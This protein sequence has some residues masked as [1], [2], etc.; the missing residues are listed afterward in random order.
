[1]LAAVLMVTTASAQRGG[2]PPAPP[3]TPRAA[4]PVDLTGTWVAV[5]TED[6][7]WRMTTPKKGDYA[8]VPLNPAGRTLADQWTPAEEGSCKA[9]GAAALLRHPGRLRISWQGDATLKIE[10]DAGTQT[11]LLQFT[12]D[13]AVA[14][15]RTLQGVSRAQW[16]GVAPAWGTLKV[17]TTGLAAG[18]LRTNG[19]PYSENAVVTEYFD[20]FSDEGDEWF[21]VTTIVEDPAYLTQPFITSSNFRRE[22]DNSRWSPTTCKPS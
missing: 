17:V 6:W 11:R 9:Y 12:N 16:Q 3:R 10:T 7:H 19:V 13:A 5:I 21:A 20:R 22:P 2:G 15:A 1:M 8:S 14:G 18:W 4:A